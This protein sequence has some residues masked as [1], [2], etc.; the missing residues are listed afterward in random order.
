MKAENLEQCSKTNWLIFYLKER[1]KEERGKQGGMYDLSI[2]FKRSTYT[3][4]GEIP[5][6]Q[7]ERFLTLLELFIR[8]M[9]DELVENGV[10][11]ESEERK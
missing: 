4:V 8:G 9:E 2:Q 10:E 3:K 11:L 1:L 7:K 6:H 5:G